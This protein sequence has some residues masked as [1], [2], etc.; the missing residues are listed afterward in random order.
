[1]T[2]SQRL[3]GAAGDCVDRARRRRKPSRISSSMS[4][5]MASHSPLT[6]QAVQFGLQ[7]APAMQFENLAVGRRRSVE[8]DL[9]ACADGSGG[10]SSASSLPVTTNTGQDTWKSLRSRPERCMPRSSAGVVTS[11]K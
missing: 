6:G 3:R 8:G 7:V 11:S 10:A 9:L 1:M 2:P 5:P 4:E